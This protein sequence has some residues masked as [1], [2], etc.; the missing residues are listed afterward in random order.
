MSLAL[1]IAVVLIGALVLLIGAAFVVS[2]VRTARA[3]A[4]YPPEGRIVTVNGTR[5]HAVVQGEGPDV[6]LIHG[7]SGSTR[8]FTFRLA[9]ALADRYRV[10]TFDRPGLGYTDPL[11][12]GGS[13]TEQAALLQAAATELGA[14]RPIVLGQSYG[15]AV[16]LAWAVTLPD[17]LSALVPVSSP[18]QPWDGPLP[19]LYEVNSSWW[20]P[21][22]AIPLIS[23]F[24]PE[25][26][27]ASQLRAVFAPQD[28]TEGFDDYIGAE[29]VIRR[30]S[31]RANA[32]QRASLLDEITELKPRYDEITVPIELVHGD[33]DGTVPF[34][35][36]A[37]PFALQVPE[38]N[39]TRLPGI[40]HLPQHVAT[41]EVIAAVDRAAARAGL[42]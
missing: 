19:W 8:D 14:D 37:E 36:H 25:S 28:M 3:E 26:Y 10:I 12:G 1:K 39:V 29:L 40:G 32:L 31:L 9:P 22:T 41:D 34:E 5:V 7:S 13:I 23:A 17:S 4:A 21:V 6:V 27:I 16:A 20:A 15:G 30:E 24:T 2:A 38:A 42:R 35:I 18:T 33:A 11:P